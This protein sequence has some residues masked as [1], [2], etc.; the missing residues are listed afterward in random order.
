[1]AIAQRTYNTNRMNVYR[2]A[3]RAFVLGG[4]IFWALIVVA[5]LMG[6]N[7]EGWFLFAGSSQKFMTALTYSFVWIAIAAVIFVVGL[8]Y[9]RIAAI[10]L[11]IAAGGAVYYGVDKVWEMPLWFVVGIFVILPILI[12]AVLYLLAAN[13]QSISDKGG[14]DTAYH[15]PG[16]ATT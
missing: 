10:L 6:A 8:F 11:F 1:M 2:L 15:P 16:E 4:A 7:S 5:G 12:S 3:A 9:E 13:E 14:S